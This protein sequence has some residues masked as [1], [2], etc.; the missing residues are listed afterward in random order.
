MPISIIRNI[1]ILAPVIMSNLSFWGKLNKLREIKLDEK[2]RAEF[3]ANLSEFI[4]RD[5]RA[6]VV[7]RQQSKARD[8]VLGE[9]KSIWN[10]LIK[11]NSLIKFNPMP[12]LASLVIMVLLGGG[13]SFAAENSLPG[14]TLYPVKVKF[15]E[16]VRGVLSFGEESKTEWEA[17]RVERRL[18]EA[19]ELAASGALSSDVSAKIE[20]NFE[21][22]ARRVED[23][24]AR[25]EA[26][27]KIMAA[28]DLA[29][30][31]ETSLRV[32]DQIL[33]RLA[34]SGLIPAAQFKAQME[35]IATTS[36]GTATGAT[37][38]FAAD[39]RAAGISSIK[40]KVKQH[41]SDV[42]AKRIKFDEEIR[43]RVRGDNDEI[44]VETKT[45]AE[46]K[47]GAAKNVI[48]SVKSF[49]KK[50]KDKLGAEAAA[51]A[52]ARITVAEGLVAQAEARAAADAHGEAFN[53][54][55]E[56]IRV[57]QAAR[58]LVNASTE[59]DLKIK[60]LGPVEIEFE[61]DNSGPG[62]SGTSTDDDDEEEDEVETE[63]EIEAHATS[64][65]GDDDNSGSGVSGSGGLK[66][67][68]GL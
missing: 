59:L 53:L 60:F 23:R 7:L 39:L 21:E 19:A 57:A 36:T 37:T 66:L 26:E 28:A 50:Q 2:H 30:K 14:N 11:N 34:L 5:V 1:C 10:S 3:R 45:A 46:G 64:G 13:V 32:H 40:I 4:E 20:E 52:E 44:R 67:K 51:D 54:A 68:L 29:S 38:T 49:I 24:I 18:E 9:R 47:I 22:H 27:N 15:N 61:N 17:R 6:E 8:R 42:S 25:F 33:E 65:A 55:N 12:I 31:F 43:I 58:V 63:I 35:A 48:A 56:A 41:L 16:E 62:K